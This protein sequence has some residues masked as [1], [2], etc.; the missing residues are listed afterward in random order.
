M[1]S[2][3]GVKIGRSAPRAAKDEKELFL[4]AINLMRLTIHQRCNQMIPRIFHQIWINRQS[5]ELPADLAAYRDGWMK[6]HPEWDYKLWN[7]E[8][9]DFTPSRPDLIESATSYAQVADILRYELLARHGGIYLDTDFQCLKCIDPIL[10][11][12]D[13]FA[14]SEDGQII[15]VGILG[16]TPG[17]RY[18]H[19]VIASLPDRVGVNPPNTETGPDFFTQ[20]LLRQGVA[21]DFTIFPQ[22]WFYP[23]NWDEPHRAGEVFPEAFAVHRW[24]HSWKDSQTPDPPPLRQRLRRFWSR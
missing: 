24:A 5:P 14:C 19:R 9:I 17:S 16:A 1:P 6:M 15:S 3:E 18:M 21:G 22:A 11:G 13:N 12:V 20:V 4:H 2:E 8:T 10:D 23:Y 7:L